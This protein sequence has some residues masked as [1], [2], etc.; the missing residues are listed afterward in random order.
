MTEETEPIENE[1]TET[2]DTS[3]ADNIDEVLEEVTGE[4]VA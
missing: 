2:E 4:V 1:P 3:G